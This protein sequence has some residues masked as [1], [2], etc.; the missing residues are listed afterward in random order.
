MLSRSTVRI[1]MTR[2]GIG[3]WLSF[4]N[5]ELQHQSLGHRTSRQIYQESLWICGRSAFPTG[6]ASSASPASSE[7]GEML[8]F[9]HIPTGDTED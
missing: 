9:A 6:S 5:E 4:H 8:A 7:G 2:T 3:A 1:S